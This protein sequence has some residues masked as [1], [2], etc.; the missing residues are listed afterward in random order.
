M[1]GLDERQTNR[2]PRAERIVTWGLYN[3]ELNYGMQRAPLIIREL[4]LKAASCKQMQPCSSLELAASLRLWGGL[5]SKYHKDQLNL[6][7]MYN[8][9][10]SCYMIGGL[11]SGSL[12]TE[13][14]AS[15]ICLHITTVRKK[16][17]LLVSAYA[18]TYEM[19]KAHN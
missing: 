12:F 18:R 10:N 17:E 5:G 14:M 6:C 19:N 15:A 3:W 9:Q 13:M 1:A 4:L 16:G 2:Q 7:K 8:S 11:Q